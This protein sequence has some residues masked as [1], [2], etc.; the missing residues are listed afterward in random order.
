MCIRDR[1]GAVALDAAVVTA[2]DAIQVLGGIGF[3]WE[4][5]AHLYLRRAMSTR[6]WLRGTDVWRL[7]LADL[8]AA[9]VRRSAHVD[10]GE[11]AERV[12]SSVREAVAEVAAAPGE[13]R[14]EVLT[15]T[16][17]LMPHW[18]APYGRDAGPVE[19]LVI[20]EELEAAGIAKPSLAIG[21]W[22]A[23][24]IVQHGTDEQRK[25][26]LRPTLAGEITW[27]Q[28][29]SEPGAGSDLASLRTRSAAPP[30]STCGRRR[31]PDRARSASRSR[32]RSDPPTSWRFTIARRR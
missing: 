26:F 27:C 4:H 1:A 24:T 18:P 19:Q 3:T 8:A 20:D 5:D 22:A 31:T 10:L 16:G 30:S 29:F 32:Q 6:L 9:G 12:R 25:R 14:R 2:Q 13:R 7:L 23:P 28:L 15:D 21:A 11:E 17:L